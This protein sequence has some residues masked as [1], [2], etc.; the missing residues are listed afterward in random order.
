MAPAPA[1]VATTWATTTGAAGLVC[2]SCTACCRNEQIKLAP[3]DD[4]GRYD[5]EVRADGIW[6]AARA[7]G[8]P[9]CRYLGRRGCSIYARR[10]AACRAFDCRAYFLGKSPAAIAARLQAS[11]GT[12]QTFRAAI[13]RLHTLEPGPVRRAAPPSQ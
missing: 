11:P 13:A 8:R 4:P 5:I 9:G 1:T 3:G 6:I 12:A 10:P 7:D 2:G